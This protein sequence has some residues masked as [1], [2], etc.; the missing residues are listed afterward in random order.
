MDYLGLLKGEQWL[1]ISEDFDY[2]RATRDFVGLKLF[3]MVR[4]DNM[5]LAIAQLAEGSDV[6]VM[7]LVHALDTEAKI[8]DRPDYEE[9]RYELL[10]VK[11]KL[12]QGEALRKK[13]KDMG[14]SNTEK[15]IIN[16]V[17]NDASN[18]I[19]KV[20][21]RFEVM[22]LEA[23]ATGKLTIDENNAKVVIDYKIPAKHF[24]TVSGW[25]T[26]STDILGDLIKIKRNSKNKIVRAYTS[27]DV[28]G[29]ILNNAKLAEIAAKQGTYVTEDWALTYIQN[30]IGIEFV[31][32]DETYKD[33]YQNG[34]ERNA[35]PSNVITFATTD[36][37]LGR[38]FMTSTPSEDCQLSNSTRTGFVSIDQWLGD[39][40]K[41]V[42][43]EAEGLGLP[44]YSDVNKI[45]ICKV[46][47]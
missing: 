16:E 1:A 33:R 7:A 41:T 8:G 19:A 6:P 11:E 27:E 42:W 25:S 38:T 18:L 34:T 30:L 14:M 12:N 24:L 39:D 23:L 44:V 32:I 9:I 13:L 5:K 10:L 2:V 37:V 4:T 35:Y 40:P 36:G 28:I 3:P 22:A 43:T 17:Y 29:Y 47:A 31:V 21:T 26:A 15:T 45:Y 20:L 46:G